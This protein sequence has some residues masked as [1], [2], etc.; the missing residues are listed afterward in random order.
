MKKNIC[1]YIVILLFFI[2]APY[3]YAGEEATSDLYASVT[4]NK[5]FMISLDEA[6]IDFGQLEPGQTVEL[7]ET[8]AYNTIKCMSNK[9]LTWHLKLSVIGDIQ[10]PAGSEVGVEDFKWKIVGWTG[11]GAASE[12]WRPFSKEKVLV[13]TSGPRDMRGHDVDIRFKYKLDLPGR[14]KGGHYSAKVL[15]T[16]TETP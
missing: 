1:I 10:V 3:L 7:Y 9:G 13:Y 5:I 14:A 8:R 16:M 2:I 12:G 11:D 4:V 6:Y 15:Y